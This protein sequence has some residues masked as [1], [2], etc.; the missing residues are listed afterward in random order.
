[1]TLLPQAPGCWDFKHAPPH[2]AEFEMLLSGAQKWSCP[3]G[4]WVFRLET[5]RETD[6]TV[7]RS[8]VLAEVVEGEVRGLF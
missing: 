4:S 8:C 1:M 3:A 2:L 6:L 5:G 7:F